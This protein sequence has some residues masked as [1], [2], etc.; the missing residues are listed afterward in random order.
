M[1]YLA[2]SYQSPNLNFKK[3]I[4]STL[5]D[6]QRWERCMRYT[7][8]YF[9][10]AVDALHAKHYINE[11]RRSEVMKLYQGILDGVV[12]NILD[13]KAG[14]QTAKEELI[15]TI[16]NF[17]VFIGY[18]PEVLNKTNLI[19]NYKSF[20]P[21]DGLA[22]RNFRLTPD[23][24]NPTFRKTNPL[25]GIQFFELAILVE[26]RKYLNGFR[27]IL[28]PNLLDFQF[29]PETLYKY[30][31]SYFNRENDFVCKFW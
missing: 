21:I 5:K 22:D 2:K 3:L 23:Y 9:Q 26:D 20:W 15:E 28:E 6:V 19:E 4:D 12:E 25:K 7:E 11:K 30:D 31:E 24:I 10:Y 14:N 16:R 29:F 18:R 17:K 27:K 13:S 1:Q 8:K